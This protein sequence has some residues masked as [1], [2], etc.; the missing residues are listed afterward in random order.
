MDYEIAPAEYLETLIRIE[1]SDLANNESPA[2]PIPHTT[3]DGTVR[4]YAEPF[5]Y[6]PVPL[7]KIKPEATSGLNICESFNKSVWL[8]GD[9]E[10]DLDSFWDVAGFDILMHFNS[11][12]I[13][14]VD[15][16]IDPDG[17]FAAFW[18]GGVQQFM[19]VANNTLGYVWVAFS[20]IP[21]MD[22]IGNH[23]SPF[24]KGRLFEVTFHV[25]YESEAYPPPS[26]SVWLKNREPRPVVCTS[27]GDYFY[28]VT[29][30]VNV[31]GYLHPERNMCPW[32]HKNQSVFLPHLVE[33]AT[34]T[35]LFSRPKGPQIDLYT[36]YPNPWGGQGSHNFSDMFWI[37]RNV[38]LQAYVTYNLYPEQNKDVSFTVVDPHGDI[39]GNLYGR[40]NG[41]GLA[42]VDFRVPWTLEDP[43]YWLGEWFVIA[44]VD[45]A[46]E[47]V[48]D[49][50]SFKYDY[51]V[52]TWDVGVDKVF[53]MLGETIEITV[54][55]GSYAMRNYPIT[56]TVTTIDESGCLFGYDNTTLSVGGAEYCTYKNGTF[57]FY[58]QVPEF[59][60]TGSAEIHVGA[61]DWLGVPITPLYT[62]I[63][64]IGALVRDMAILSVWPSVTEIYRG[65]TVEISI[66]V[67]NQGSTPERFN[68]NVSAND[69][70]I[71]GLVATALEAGRSRT[72]TLLWNTTLVQ[73]GNYILKAEIPP[74]PNEIN[75][76]N[77]IFE[78]GI[79]QIKGRPPPLRDIAVLQ[80]QPNNTRVYQGETVSIRVIVKNQGTRNETFTLTVYHDSTK[81]RALPVSE[82]PPQTNLTLTVDWDTTHITPGK[83]RIK[84]NATVL[85]EETKTDNNE[86]VNGIVEILRFPSPPPPPGPPLMN[87]RLFLVCLILALL[88]LLAKLILLLFW[89]YRRRKRRKTSESSQNRNW[90]PAKFDTLPWTR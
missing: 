90:A 19:K 24:G 74:L 54:D 57:K 88:A 40:T 27:P 22:P 68:V 15:V 7:L 32:H 38:R 87:P 43:E 21:A 52:R 48:N 46:E 78:N 66:L 76:M 2:R 45:V 71:D 70:V 51:L 58:I 62:T 1:E 25:L 33:N 30:T 59:A 44:K 36:Q 28:N 89:C 5:E 11:T 12:L 17:W 20:G 23:T 82:L 85:P 61:L 81:I 79:V 49:T 65:E 3:T 69:K 14:A 13:E 55:Y 75:V 60:H 39:Y 4:L 9:G 29:M 80:V 34:Y 6:P 50:L 37:Q 56:Y 67:A 64:Q 31:T 86:L 77:N 35:A 47:I 53:Y 16:N 83:Y 8:M 41:H 42:T 73:I 63:I 72:F 26:T 10:T 18:P 84:A